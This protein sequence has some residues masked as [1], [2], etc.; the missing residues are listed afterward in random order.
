MLDLG[1]LY[2]RRWTIEQCFQNPK[3][4]G[5]QLENSYLR[6]RHKL[7]KLLALVTLAYAFC[8][9]VGQAAD[10]RTP[11]AHKKH[12]YRATSLARNDLNILRQITRPATA[13]PVTNCFA[14][15]GHEI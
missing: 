11:I 2:A 15:R 1:Q 9:G 12:G 13:I 4:R 6:C 5:F 10:R 14:N 7:R 3:G 8:L